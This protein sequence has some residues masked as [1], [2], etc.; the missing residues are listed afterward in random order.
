[1]MESENKMIFKFEERALKWL[2]DNIIY[3]AVAAAFLLSVLIRISLRNFYSFDADSCLIPWY[4]AMKANGGIRGLAVPIEGCNYNFPYMLLVAI[5]TY[6]PVP[7]LF[8]YKMFSC[9][10]DYIMAVGVAMIVRELATERKDELSAFAFI[11]VIM[12]PTVFLDSAAWAQ[13]DSIY[14]SFIVWA[15]YFL[16]KNKNI[17]A[18]V[19][20][21]LAFAFKFHFIFA[22]PFLVFYYF[23][24]RRFTIL[25]FLLIPVPMIVLSL[26]ALVQGRTI[27]EMISIYTDNTS[28]H[29]SISNGYPTF[30]RILNDGSY[31]DSYDTLKTAAIVFT[32]V[33]LGCLVTY[34]VRRQ[35]VLDGANIVYIA[36]IFTYTTVLFLPAMHERYGFVYE[37]LALAIACL[38]PRTIPLAAGLIGLSMYTYGAYLYNQSFNE[39]IP[40]IVNVII[41]IAYLYILFRRIFID[42]IQKK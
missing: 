22:L 36:F 30:W 42:R 25:H 31:I 7:A 33:A 28:L 24:K 4:D 5:M 38:V 20:Y 16:I 18:F 9:L 23:Y 1:M 15:I 3:V 11:A 32:V 34:L 27:S 12:A 19:F 17:W 26:P 35:I 37:I 41:Y 6:L 14:S 2:A 40:A 13:C 10:F 39:T 21:G 29:Q 8:A